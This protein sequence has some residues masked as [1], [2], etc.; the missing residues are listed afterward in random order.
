MVLLAV[1]VMEKLRHLPRKDL[2]NLGLVVLVLIVAILIIK[3]AAKMNR[4]L[5]FMIILVTTIVV[6]FTWVYQ[7]SEP[8]FLTPLVDGIAPFFPHRP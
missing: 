5:L 4:F 2:A 7:R 6:G 8:K 3:Q 1:N